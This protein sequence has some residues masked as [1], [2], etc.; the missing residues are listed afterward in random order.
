MDRLRSC[1][2]DISFRLKGYGLARS[3]SRDLGTA[4]STLQVSLV[5]AWRQENGARGGPIADHLSSPAS[6][7]TTIPACHSNWCNTLI[8]CWSSSAARGTSTATETWLSLLTEQEREREDEAEY[9]ASREA[10]RC[11]ELLHI[12]PMC[13]FSVTARTIVDEVMHFVALLL[14]FPI[15]FVV[16]APPRDALLLV[17]LPL[18]TWFGKVLTAE[19]QE[20][21]SGSYRRPPSLV[22]EYLSQTPVRSHV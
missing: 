16:G 19:I 18:S 11:I 4:Y 13:P 21:K 15:S 7:F 8:P 6:S 22:G 3:M 12:P 1:P 5:T 10:S 20:L 14:A 17:S 2:R 9:R